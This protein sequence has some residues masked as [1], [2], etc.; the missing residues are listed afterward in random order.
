[1][2][3]GI[4]KDFQGSWGSGVATLV[5]K[6][7]RKTETIHCENAPTVRAL[8]SMF[9]GVIVEGH[10]VNVDALRG[11]R[12]QFALDDMGLMLGALAPAE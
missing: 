5:L 1:M 8:A 4:I 11:Q 12:V 7:G 9:P 2:K 3:T 6:V 10:C